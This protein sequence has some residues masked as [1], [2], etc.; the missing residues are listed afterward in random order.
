ME[1]EGVP[2][3]PQL[4]ELYPGFYSP[5]AAAQAP[6]TPAPPAPV[7]CPCPSP[8]PRLV[9]LRASLCVTSK[10]ITSKLIAALQS[11]SQHIKTHQTRPEPIGS[12]HRSAFGLQALP[13]QRR[14]KGRLRRE[15]GEAGIS[16]PQP[17]PQPQLSQAHVHPHQAVRVHSSGHG[18]AETLSATARMRGGRGRV[19]PGRPHLRRRR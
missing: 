16:E 18:A 14:R 8:A 9:R 3:L 13:L 12:A 6:G 5:P 10:P 15:Y 1:T 11:L 4:H 7:C 17:K 19:G 2:E